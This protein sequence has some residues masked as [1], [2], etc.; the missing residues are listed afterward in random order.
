MHILKIHLKHKLFLNYL[1]KVEKLF[2]TTLWLQ[3]K[4]LFVNHLQDHV[5][6]IGNLFIKN[7]QPCS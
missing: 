7:Q 3:H 1:F 6:H 4:C 2:S 5:P